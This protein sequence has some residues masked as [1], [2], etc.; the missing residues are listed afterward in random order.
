MVSRV[1]APRMRG[2]LLI[3]RDLSTPVRIVA[4]Q[5]PRGEAAV[6]LGTSGLEVRLIVG[7]VLIQRHVADLLA[8]GVTERRALKRLTR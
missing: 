6:I 2:L 3:G 1:G 4:V 5:V 8:V 7:L